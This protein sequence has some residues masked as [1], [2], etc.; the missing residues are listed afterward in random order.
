MKSKFM[1]NVLPL[2]CFLFLNLVTNMSIPSLV[3]GD[4]ST[5]KQVP[6]SMYVEILQAIETQTKANYEKI[7]L[8][9]GKTKIIP[10]NHAN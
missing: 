4:I 7:Q 8:W 6:E 2:H 1:K 5:W 3:F 10:A 9:Q